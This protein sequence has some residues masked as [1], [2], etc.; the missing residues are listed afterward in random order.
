[1]P[2]FEQFSQQYLCEILEQNATASGEI[3]AKLSAASVRSL[4]EQVPDHLILS[5]WRTH[6][7]PSAWDLPKLPEQLQEDSMHLYFAQLLTLWICYKAEV[8]QSWQPPD[9]DL[10]VSV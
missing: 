6:P 10:S 8:L 7:R 1:M 4:G 9:D 3:R 2:S 5:T